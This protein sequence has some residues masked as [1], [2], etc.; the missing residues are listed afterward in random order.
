MG[1]IIKFTVSR[2]LCAFCDVFDYVFDVI[3]L[4]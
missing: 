1:Q 3:N 2:R 4:D